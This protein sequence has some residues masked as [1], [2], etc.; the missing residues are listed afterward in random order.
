MLEEGY[1]PFML[2]TSFVD[3]RKL[4]PVSMASTVIDV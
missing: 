3:L 2:K 4:S 1:D